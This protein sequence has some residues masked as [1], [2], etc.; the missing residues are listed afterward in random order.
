MLASVIRKYWHALVRDIIALGYR[1]ED[2]P[3]GT[4]VFG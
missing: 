3:N 2:T 4:R 1:V